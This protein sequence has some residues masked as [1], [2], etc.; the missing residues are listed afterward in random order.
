MVNRHQLRLLHAKGLPDSSI[1]EA[2]GIS[3]SHA[4]RVREALGLARH[5]PPPLPRSFDERQARALHAKGLVD[6]AIARALAISRE[7][8][9]KW[10]VTNG[11]K[12]NGW[13]K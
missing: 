6:R 12:P 3:V 8:I 10:R 11:L 7:T 4:W 5:N 9:Q 2:L 13:R 1:A